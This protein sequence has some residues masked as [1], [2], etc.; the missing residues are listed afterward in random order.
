MM[1]K[2]ILSATGSFPSFPTVEIETASIVLFYWD[3][4]HIGAPPGRAGPL[5]SHFVPLENQSKAIEA[6]MVFR[7]PLRHLL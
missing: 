2:I 5:I 3:N 4:R 7:E 1:L 6:T